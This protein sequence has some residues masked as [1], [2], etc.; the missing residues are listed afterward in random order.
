MKPDGSTGLNTQ[1]GIVLLRSELSCLCQIPDC[2]CL[3]PRAS[4]KTS[5]KSSVK[6][7]K[8]M[9]SKMSLIPKKVERNYLAT[10]TDLEVIGYVVPIFRAK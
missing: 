6:T 10:D 1:T 7:E 3:I 5:L 4:L 2:C 8:G 9:A